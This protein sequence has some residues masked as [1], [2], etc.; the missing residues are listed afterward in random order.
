M[1]WEFDLSVQENLQKL[2]QFFDSVKNLYIQG[3]VEIVVKEIAK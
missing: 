1:K 3:K 2:E